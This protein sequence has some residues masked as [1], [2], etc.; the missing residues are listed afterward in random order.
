MPPGT[1]DARGQGA[2]RV[3][4]VKEMGQEGPRQLP[5]TTR[6][7]ASVTLECTARPLRRALNQ[8]V[9]TCAAQRRERLGQLTDPLAEFGR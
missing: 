5:P 9:D 1:L 8:N 3:A 6:Q 4:S 2:R 7:F